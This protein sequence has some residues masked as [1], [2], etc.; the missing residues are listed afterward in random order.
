MRILEFEIN[1][2]RGIKNIILK[3][4]G[5][6]FVIWGPNGSGKSAVVDALDF[7]LT[8]RISRLMG[9]GT[10]HITL[11]GYGPH[12]DHDLEE[13]YVRAIIQIPGSSD[14]IEL[15]RCMSSPTRLEYDSSLIDCLKPVLDIADKGQHVLSRREILKYITSEAG[16][17]AQEIQELLN[18]TEIE[19]FRRT[20]VKVNTELEK[21]LNA[22]KHSLDKTKESIK[23]TLQISEFSDE[24]IIENINNNRKILG[25]KDIS[26]LSSKGIISDIE[27]PKIVSEKQPI[28]FKLI[29]QY[30]DNILSEISEEE[31]DR[32]IR[33][34]KKLREIL[35][36]V[37]KNNDLRQ[38]LD[39]I[40]LIKLGKDLIP[41]EGNCPLCGA[42]WPTGELCIHLKTRLSNAKK[43]QTYYE[44]IQEQC[45]TIIDKINTISANLENILSAVEAIALTEEYETLK[46]WDNSL[47]ELIQAL[48]EPINQYTDES[49]DRKIISD[50]LAPTELDHIFEKVSQKLKEKF[51]D[52]TP[53]HNAW[54]LLIRVEENFK[55]FENAKISLEK[56][57]ISSK[58]ALILKES[59]E[60]SRDSI[61]EHLYNDIKDRFVELYRHIHG[62]DECNFSAKIAPDGAG[63]ELQVDFYERGIHPPHAL[64]SEGHQDSM[65]LCLYLAL[66][67]YLTHGIIDVMILDDV[68]MSVDG[69]H[70][71]QICC[72]L[73]E[74]FPH[75]QFIIT[76]HD[77]TWVRQLKSEGVVSSKNIVEFYNWDIE[78]GPKMNYLVDLWDKI[79]EDLLKSDIPSA[80]AKLRRGSEEYF[81]MVCDYIEAKVIFKLDGN[82]SLG[83]LLPA[84][85]TQY[86]HIIK[87]AK[88]SADS[89]DNEEDIEMFRE[90][91]SNASQIFSRTNV[92]QWGLNANVHYTNWANF[93]KEDFLP[94]VEAFQDLFALYVCSDCGSI[95][96]LTKSGYDYSSLRCNCG[97]V[98]WNLVET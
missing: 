34:D 29:K 38:D 18:I 26:E 50:L 6:N 55:A 41:E 85:I 59:F 45:K 5:K 53:L 96:R 23:S 63:L 13:A 71:K 42:S 84:A 19:T 22:T 66:A 51:P 81:S 24:L 4:D 37:R 28:N 73:S 79:N 44:A 67:E 74:K 7:L 82:W 56:S 9:K 12:I 10:G 97:K 60:E 93:S 87:K 46:S 11:R 15:R 94:L 17:R 1:N 2:V 61:L 27:V 88:K 65:G 20:L 68:V 35:K 33:V 64:H 75:R 78:T 70:R 54:A 86:N 92:E 48:D 3:P 89:W 76:T 25:A 39:N 31:R 30:I 62:T 32:I 72:L 95:L 91:E 58:R 14:S 47:K 98:N 69:G 8:G 90:L 80:A 83:D 57:E 40:K 43:A 21:E 77:K 52:F 36:I 16:T 49:Y